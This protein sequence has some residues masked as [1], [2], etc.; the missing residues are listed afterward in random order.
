MV[1][2]LSAMVRAVKSPE[3]A[4]LLFC[5]GFLSKESQDE[6]ADC[7]DSNHYVLWYIHAH[8]SQKSI[9]SRNQNVEIYG[10]AFE[11]FHSYLSYVKINTLLKYY[12][13]LLS[14]LHTLQE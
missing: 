8:R 11:K 14:R 12:P 5:D 1:N 9:D 2:T 13:L 7:Q 3:I 10:L 4:I 6:I